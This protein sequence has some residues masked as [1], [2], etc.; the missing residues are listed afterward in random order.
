MRSFHATVLDTQPREQ[1]HCGG[2]GG[3]TGT[4]VAIACPRVTA[5]ATVVYLTLFLSVSFKSPQ[6]CVMACLC[7]IRCQ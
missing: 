2:S 6:A 3:R 1:D 7:N 4:N 5:W